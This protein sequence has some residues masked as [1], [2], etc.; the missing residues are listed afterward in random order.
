MF[1][2]RDDLQ[3]EW[4]GKRTRR[5]QARIDSNSDC[6]KQQCRCRYEGHGPVAASQ[7]WQFRAGRLNRTSVSTP[8]FIW[9]S[10][11]CRFCL[12]ELIYMTS[13]KPVFKNG[14]LDRF[15]LLRPQRIIDQSEPLQ[16]RQKNSKSIHD[17]LY[18]DQALLNDHCCRTIDLQILLL[19]LAAEFRWDS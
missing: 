5:D 19:E 12:R 18:W 15:R 2:Q 9:S 1:V 16:L 4:F 8:F 3:N 11:D 6:C 10:V 14:Y 7:F 13:T 17:V